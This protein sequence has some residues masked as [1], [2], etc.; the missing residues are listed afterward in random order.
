[1]IFDDVVKEA[2]EKVEGG[3]AALLM[4][5]D[6]ISLSNYVKAG[7]NLEMEVIGVEYATLL[8]EIRKTNEIMETGKVKEICVSTDK[9]AIIVRSIT[10]DYFIALALTPNGNI[11]KGRFLLRVNAPRLQKEF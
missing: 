2:V 8:G 1:M 7:A 3:L 9:F 5:L 11:G 10:P 6:G 4:G